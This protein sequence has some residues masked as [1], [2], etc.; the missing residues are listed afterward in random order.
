M[1]KRK[2]RKKQQSVIDTDTV[3][4]LDAQ[5]EARRQQLREA[6]AEARRRRG[7]EG[8]EAEVSGSDYYGFKPEAPPETEAVQEEQKAAPKKKRKKGS[9]PVRIAV[10]AIAFIAVICVACSGWNILSLKMEEKA[11]RELIVQLEAEKKELLSEVGSIGTEEYI[12]QQAR[13][14]LKMAKSGEIIYIF[15]DSDTE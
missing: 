11:K 12:E 7:M 10:F 3:I 5:R 9:A 2:N 4:D 8:A 15:D 13:Q 1:G 6:A 14:W